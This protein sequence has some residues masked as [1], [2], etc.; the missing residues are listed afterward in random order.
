MPEASAATSITTPFVWDSNATYNLEYGGTPNVV[1]VSGSGSITMANNAARTLN[2]ANPTTGNDGTLILQNG[3]SISNAVTGNGSRAL[4][5][6]I[7]N[8]TNAQGTLIIGGQLGSPQVAGQFEGGSSGL[9]TISST[10]TGASGL[11]LFNYTDGVFYL[12]KGAVPTGAGI[13]IRGATRIQQN[14]TGT[15]YIA[16]TSDAHDYTGTTIV[17]NGILVMVGAKS[18]AGST[19]IAAGATLRVGNGGTTGSWVGPIATSAGGSLIFSRSTNYEIP[20]SV[21]MTGDGDITFNA[22]GSGYLRTVTGATIN[23]ADNIYITGSGPVTLNGPL[24]DIGNLFIN[25]SASTTIASLLNSTAYIE[26]QGSGTAT[27]TAGTTSGNISINAGTLAFGGNAA[28]ATSPTSIYVGANATLRFNRSAA[29]TITSAITGPGSLVKLGSAL[30]LTGTNLY[31]GGTTITGSLILSG[32]GT[33]GTGAIILRPDS[34]LN[35][36]GDGVI[37]PNTIDR[38]QTSGTAASITKTGSGTVT[39][40]GDIG[41]KKYLSG[42]SVTGGSLV[43]GNGGTPPNWGIHAGNINI[44]TGASLVFNHDGF[45]YPYVRTGVASVDAGHRWR[46]AFQG[47]GDLI[48]RGEG[49]TA[50]MAYNNTTDTLSGRL[51]AERGTFQIGM[52]RDRGQLTAAIFDIRTNGTIAVWRKR[53]LHDDSTNTRRVVNRIIGDGTFIKKGTNFVHLTNADTDFSGTYIVEGGGLRFGRNATNEH[54]ITNSTAD[55]V[56]QRTSV[57]DATKTSVLVIGNTGNAMHFS[58]DI[59]GVGALRKLSTSMLVLT[60]DNSYSGGTHIAGGI[61]SGNLSTNLYTT[62]AGTIQVGDFDAAYGGGYTGSLGTGTVLFSTYSTAANNYGN[63]LI[64]RNGTLEIPGNIVGGNNWTTPGT[65]NTITHSGGNDPANPATTILSGNNSFRGSII[66]E[67]GTVILSGNNTDSV[68][69]NSNYIVKPGTGATLQIGDG[70]VGGRIYQTATTG[71]TSAADNTRLDFRGATIEINHADTV[72]WSRPLKGSVTT[73]SPTNVQYYLYNQSNTASKF[74]QTG[75]G[76][77]ILSGTNTAYEGTIQ[78]D[79][80]RLQISDDTN[81]GASSTNI[82]NGGTL[83]LAGNTTKN[84]TLAVGERENGI[85]VPSAVTA[86]FEGTLSEEGGFTKL[87]AG[88]LKLINEYD[89]GNIVVREGVLDLTTLSGNL[90]IYLVNS[91][92]EGGTLKLGN[93]SGTTNL[94][95]GWKIAVP[96]TGKNTIDITSGTSVDGWVGISGAGDFTVT[97]GGTLVLGNSIVDPQYGPNPDFSGAVTI[98]G[99]QLQ[100]TVPGALGGTVGTPTGAVHQLID[101]TLTLSS[102][103]PTTYFDN[104]HVPGRTTLQQP[105]INVRENDVITLSGRLTSDANAPLKFTG[106]PA[107]SA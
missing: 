101:G 93:T 74:I 92:L 47:G 62:N 38:F 8:G 46:T 26:K 7:A 99:G 58:G 4:T 94:D 3:G 79:N 31:T 56:L 20:T 59:S 63:I 30:T 86:I 105:I 39:L 100:L 16:N 12:T 32:G 18:G 14:S 2:I 37:L 104:W 55:F 73:N 50:L 57:K 102:A 70:G 9:I 84:W 10:G 11:L 33:L 43:L 87:G 71:S 35:L 52:G 19:T 90:G 65:Y 72:T 67:R 34:I 77:T 78:I 107:M 54:G 97:G 13:R 36:N 45:L 51:I 69:N 48:N 44:A 49:I 85:E 5:V 25:S 98:D 60:G 21:K 22:A 103:T 91:S 24:T 17:N 29:T 15:T 27:I 42:L 81:L 106:N 82:I 23:G 41:A 66:V 6:N 64:N 96:A 89:L 76:T 75:T 61:G 53:D 80:G 88:T 83:V 95:S 68:G 40:T 1:T 28:W